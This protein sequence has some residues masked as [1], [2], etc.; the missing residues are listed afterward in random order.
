MSWRSSSS[1]SWRSSS[2]ESRS[3]SSSSEAGQW[4]DRWRQNAPPSSAGTQLSGQKRPSP[5]TEQ[6][7][8]AQAR[9]FGGPK[10]QPPHGQAGGGSAWPMQ[11]QEDA[12]AAG[13]E[14]RW[15]NYARLE[16]QFPAAPRP[17]E[18]PRGGMPPPPPPGI[19]PPP[20]PGIPPPPPGAPPERVPPPPPGPSSACTPRTRARAAS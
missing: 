8:A 6:F 9:M 15:P 12:R 20:P 4:N 7:L 19:P 18:P 17:R 11:H 10:T 16:Q 5:Q 13:G 3:A 2:S 14:R 1:E